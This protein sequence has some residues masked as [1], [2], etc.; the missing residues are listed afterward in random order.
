[1]MLTG[2]A[3]SAPLGPPAH[4]VPR[5][6]W[7]AG[8]LRL[9]AERQGIELSVDTLQLLVDRAAMSGLSRQGDV[10][11]G[12]ST[13]LVRA[14][15]GWIAVALAR[16]PDVDA[17][18]AWL[19]LDARSDDP[20]TEVT[21]RARVSTSAEMVDRGRLVGLP[22]SALGEV[23]SG[24]GDHR[25]IGRAPDPQGSRPRRLAG[26]VVVDLSSL[27]AGPL[28][29]NILQA[30]GAR[31]IKVESVGRPDGARQGS[32]AFF[33]LLN[34]GKQSVALDFTSPADR[35]RLAQLVNRAD[36]VI[37][38]SRPRALEQLGI[39][40]P[41]VL[42]RSGG[43]WV[44]ITGYGRRD[45]GRESIAF[46]DDAAVAAGLVAWHQER[47]YFCADAVAD[48]LTGMTAAV[49]AIEAFQRPEPVLL[50]MALARVAADFGGPTLAVP[51]GLV[52]VPPVARAP[53]GP[54]PELG[55]HTDA[56]LAELTPKP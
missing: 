7:L 41:E 29:S 42:S 50:D 10:S 22:V 36:I 6:R 9:H 44:S 32:A 2:P 21:A 14:Y 23:S 11:C 52:P 55:A 34:A 46:G 37:E 12:G 15:D 33:D 53:E 51:D 31:V 4:L 18:A 49:A 25:G 13:R 38:G 47:P 30:F 48:P 1:M 8:V 19:G 16:Q 39:V 45:P 54:G 24:P 35:G 20:W 5:L 27:W 43:V 17:V 26:A 28:C 56:V 40:A 3:E